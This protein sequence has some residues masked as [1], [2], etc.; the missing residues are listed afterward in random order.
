M[1]EKGQDARRVARVR[2]EIRLP[3][4]FPAR[5][6]D[7]ILRAV[8]QCKVKRHILEPPEFAVTAVAPGDIPAVGA[9]PPVLAAGPAAKSSPTLYQ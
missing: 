9:A 1:A 2:I 8:D 6:R 7:A 4:A 5:Y 3:P